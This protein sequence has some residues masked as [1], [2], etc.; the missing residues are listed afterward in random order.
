MKLL[1]SVLIFILEYI[2]MLFAIVCVAVLFDLL[3][4]ALIAIGIPIDE[5]YMCQCDL[6]KIF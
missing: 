2:V 4:H 3:T 6:L 5:D 1:K